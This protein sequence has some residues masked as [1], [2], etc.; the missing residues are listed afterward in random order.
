MNALLIQGP[1]LKRDGMVRYRPRYRKNAN[2]KSML[3]TSH[4]SQQFMTQ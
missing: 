1:D 4:V 2:A 3:P